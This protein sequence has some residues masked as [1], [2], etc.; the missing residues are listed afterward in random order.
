MPPVVEESAD[1]PGLPRDETSL[2]APEV[3]NHA[4]E[5]RA[6][7]RC[8]GRIWHGR[9]SRIEALVGKDAVP[10]GIETMT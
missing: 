8:V 5:E 4:Q 2:G 3:A 6:R 9:L 7:I 1:K 10:G